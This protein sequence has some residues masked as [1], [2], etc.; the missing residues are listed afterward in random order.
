MVSKA[1]G[2]SFGLL[3]P[4][5]AAVAGQTVSIGSAKLRILLAALLLGGD[6]PVSIRGLAE[7]IWGDRQPEHPRR[8]VQ[9][10]IARLRR[11]VGSETVVTSTDGYRI[12][13]ERHQLDVGRFA[14]WLQ[15]ADRAAERGAHEWE[16][17]A[18]GE[19]LRLWRGEPLVDVASELL[20]RETVPAL[21][22]QRMRVLERRIDVDLD[23]GRHTDLVAELMGLTAQHPLRGRLWAQLMTALHRCGRRAEALAA[24]RAA[25]QHLAEELGTVLGEE[26][27]QLHAVILS[28]ASTPVPRQLPPRV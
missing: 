17:R 7:A 10:G 23:L 4:L 28:G 16:S 8:T 20:Q 9:L 25:R 12:D 22:E 14:A 21:R 11:I 6:R 27:R 13:I 3:G 18:L 1:Q 26:L 5:E 19:A 24:Y 15:K 2:L